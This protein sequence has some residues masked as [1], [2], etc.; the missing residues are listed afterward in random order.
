MEEEEE[1]K[2][3]QK[4]KKKVQQIT[5][6]MHNMSPEELQARVGIEG[7]AQLQAMIET[8]ELQDRIEKV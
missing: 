4:R 2:R 3:L 8:G 1:E 5:T 6:M 7:P